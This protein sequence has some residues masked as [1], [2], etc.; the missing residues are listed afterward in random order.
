[1][2]DTKRF[3]SR[4]NIRLDVAWTDANPNMLDDDWHRTARHF[5]CTVHY[6]RRRLTVPFSQ[7]CA[8]EQEPT[9]ADVLDC[10]ASDASGL[11]GTFE[12]WCSDYGYDSDSR[13]AEKT[14]KAI[15]KQSK[16]LERLLGPELFEELVYR[17]ERL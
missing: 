9:A 2:T 5:K 11:G 3:V 8:H 6:R 15:E 7:G 12:D 10:L 16:G 1:M 17:T 4:H 14:F 13:N